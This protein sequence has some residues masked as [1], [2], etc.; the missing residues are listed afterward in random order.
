MTHIAH[1]QIQ[2]H[3]PPYTQHILEDGTAIST[4]ERVVKDVSKAPAPQIPTAEQFFAASDPTK[5]DIAFLKNHFY[6]EG[7]LSDP[8]EATEVLRS[9]PN[10]LALEGPVAICGDIHVR[11]DEIIRDWGNPVDTPDLF[12]GDYVDSGYFSIECVL[13]LWALKIWYLLEVLD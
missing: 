7:R 3:P 5:S 6:C 2:N 11:P 13:Y 1:A 8:K 12:L 9:E 4:Q 10:M